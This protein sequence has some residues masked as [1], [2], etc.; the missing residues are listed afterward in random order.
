M[1]TPSP[2]ALRPRLLFVRPRADHLPAFVAGHLN[3]HVQCLSQFFD[4]IVVPP[5]GDYKVLCETYRPDLAMFESGVYTA[6]PRTIR[7]TDAYPEIPKIGLL[8]ADAY[9]STRSVFFW[10]MEHWHIS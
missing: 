9:C 5:E 7:N 1:V 4:V 2:K 8:N 6:A 10:G 3:E